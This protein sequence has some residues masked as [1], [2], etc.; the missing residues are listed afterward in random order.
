M[1]NVIITTEQRGVWFAQVDDNNDLTRKT[2]TDLKNC[3]MAI[4]WGT[5]RGLQQLAQSGPT[6]KSRISEPCDIP[7]LHNV[8]AVFAVTD[9][10][11][12]VWMRS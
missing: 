1:K 5:E 9:K 6:L 11:A 10:A 2:L 3:K 8:T 4:Y 7:V 12:E